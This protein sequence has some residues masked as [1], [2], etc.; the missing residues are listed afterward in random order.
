MERN[1]RCVLD[2]S[3]LLRRV[4]CA[5][6]L[7]HA[8]HHG[9]F[10]S[11][12]R[13]G[14][15]EGR[16]VAERPSTDVHGASKGFEAK[17]TRAV[18]GASR[19]L[20]GAASHVPKVVPRT[21]QATAP[22]AKAAQKTASAG[23]N[24][25]KAASSAVKSAA[26]NGTKTV[27]AAPKGAAR[28]VGTATK[29]ATKTGGTAAKSVGAATKTAEAA[30]AGAGQ[31]VGVAPPRLAPTVAKVTRLAKSIVSGGRVRAAA[32]SILGWIRAIAHR[33]VAF[34]RELVTGNPSPEPAPS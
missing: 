25:T 8:M 34:A 12:T 26:G 29:T 11:K 24:V 23:V 18:Q 3:L 10:S 14:T 15:Q 6:R 16:D 21:T 1:A 4:R 32:R 17:T 31:R 27:A 13:T 9:F 20:A 22:V 30:V 5:R 19:H 2:R 28:V 33:V 7:V